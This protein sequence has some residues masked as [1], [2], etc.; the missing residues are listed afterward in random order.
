MK[1]TT[2]RIAYLHHNGVSNPG[3]IYPEQPFAGMIACVHDDGTVNLMAVN[4]LGEVSTAKRV[5][6]V[7][8][9][10]AAPP[11]AGTM[12]CCS[13][14]DERSVLPA[15]SLESEREA[16]GED[17]PDT[18]AGEPTHEDLVDAG[19]ATGTTEAETEDAQESQGELV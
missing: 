2:G 6:F 19:L 11:A 14:L 16:T 5:Q 13:P 12:F 10:D 1:P 3:V 7:G 17:P 18:A 4:H 15:P 8:V 9:D